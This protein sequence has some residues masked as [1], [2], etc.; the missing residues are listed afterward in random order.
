[1]QI[2]PS[3]QKVVQ[4]IVTTLVLIRSAWITLRQGQLLA[5]MQLL[6]YMHDHPSLVLCTTV[7]AGAVLTYFLLA[8]TLKSSKRPFL[9]PEEFKPL[10]LVEKVFVNHNTMWLRFRLESPSQR[11]GL[12]I[13]QHMSFRAQDT[14]GKD[15]YRSYTPVT[16]DD[17]L[18][19]VDFVIKVYPQGK[20]R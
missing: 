16:D 1:M 10:Q 14:D 17:Q 12:P 9:N 5:A 19:T 4:Q 3:L 8:P 13:G 15:V 20:M 18:G 2:I 11:L 7:A 6:E